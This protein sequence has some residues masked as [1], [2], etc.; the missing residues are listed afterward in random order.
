[1]RLVLR[2]AAFGLLPVLVGL[3]FALFGPHI[4]RNDYSA[5]IGPK[6]ERLRALGSPKVVVVGGSNVAFGVD[7][8]RLERTLCRPAINMGLH[9]SL[10]YA[11]MVNEVKDALGPGDVVVVALEY[12]NHARPERSEDILN[13]V[14][15]RYPRALA[16]VP[17]LQ[18]PK[19]VLTT[20]VMRLQFAWRS[21]RGHVLEPDFEPVY[22]AGGFNERGDMVA[23]LTLPAPDSLL[24]EAEVK[25]SVLVDEA[26]FTH[27][28]K[29]LEHARAA[30]A[31]VLFSWPS[32]LRSGTDE[33]KA[34]AIQR[35]LQERDLPLIGDPVDYFFARSLCFD[36][37]DHLDRVGRE[38]RTD[39]LL[40]DLC[41]VRPELC[42]VQHGR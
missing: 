38:L 15:D 32:R 24:S 9:G 10:G 36:T 6:H 40:R 1:M 41:A 37:K 4:S 5:G 2:V 11:F 14:V 3:L 8:E 13:L 16:F 34:Q 7:S 39:R 19:V 25:D 12:A 28:S 33:A 20:L 26:F 42:C 31:D 22:N 17:L 21:F 29:L 30:G 23:H 27:T 35:K 18:R